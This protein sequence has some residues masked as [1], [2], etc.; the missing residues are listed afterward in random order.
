[1]TVF[2]R[3]ILGLLRVVVDLQPYFCCGLM[4]GGS[5]SRN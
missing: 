1:M 4:L 2:V 5:S 3:L